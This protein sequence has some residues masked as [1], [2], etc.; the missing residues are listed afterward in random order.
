MLPFEQRRLTNEAQMSHVFVS[1][2]KENEKQVKALANELTK[3]GV[4]VWL[5]KEIEVAARWKDA[6]RVAIRKGDFFIACFSKEFE[7][8]SRTYMNEELLIAIEELRQRPSN[9]SWFIPVLLSECHVPARNIGGGETLADIQW[10]ELFS[11]WSA[12]IKR[13]LEVIQ[14]TPVEVQQY[15]ACLRSKD[16]VIRL[17]AA[18]ELGD[19]GD[20]R[21][22]PALIDALNDPDMHVR[23]EVAGALAR[24]RD[25]R[26]I[27]ALILALVDKEYYKVASQATCALMNIG[28]PAVQ[29]LRKALNSENRA[30]QKA[31][32]T[33]LEE[34]KIVGDAST[35]EAI[36]TVEEDAGDNEG[37]G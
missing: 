30:I 23:A 26:A 31:A 16:F 37:G 33:M 27:P 8:R 29:E 3:H 5:D 25:A 15:I 10:V 4:E 1:Y 14:P 34:L 11:D 21:A 36:N 7:S 18:G 9:R 2:I 12:G 20:S 19:I 17:K 24:L 32:A 28:K 22:V 35:R 6:I 13:I